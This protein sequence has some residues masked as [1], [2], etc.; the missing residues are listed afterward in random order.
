MDVQDYP[1]LIPYYLEFHTSFQEILLKYHLP[2]EYENIL[3]NCNGRF[4]V[5]EIQSH[6]KEHQDII[7]I[8]ELFLEN[9]LILL[10]RK[11]LKRKNGKTSEIIILS[12]HSDDALF[13]LGGF[14]LGQ[15]S[16][17]D[18]TII[19]IFT[20]SDYCVMNEFPKS[21][22]LIT[23]LRIKEDTLF[24]QIANARL[25]FLDFFEGPLR[26]KNQIR[27]EEIISQI[28]KKIN[29]LI[30]DTTTQIYF[31]LGIGD[32]VDHII[33][34]QAVFIL[35][36]IF[37]KIAFWGYEDLPYA[38]HNQNQVYTLV[39][40]DFDKAPRSVMI[41]DF[42]DSKCNLLKIYHSQLASNYAAAVRDYSV[43]KNEHAYEFLW[44][45]KQR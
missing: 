22:S 36:K 37:N 21:D 41:G 15:A 30:L 3:R 44:R 9:G 43:A 45:L 24:A 39:K 10:H 1:I 32:N 20:K 16:S 31:P 23:S 13:S 25:Y 14:I 5:N 34:K 40:E 19:N 17:S 27:T 4:S 6:F 7:K 26:N 11:P 42:I 33:T 18:I 38:A 29:S 12:P 28:V 35:S 8:L 2:I